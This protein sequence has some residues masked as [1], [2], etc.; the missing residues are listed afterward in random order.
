MFEDIPLIATG[1]IEVLM[2]SAGR[3]SKSDMIMKALLSPDERVA[4]EKERAKG[5]QHCSFQ[6]KLHRPV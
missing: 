5:E 3:I 1:T 4:L 6:A 2:T